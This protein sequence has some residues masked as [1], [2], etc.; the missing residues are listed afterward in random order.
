M[1]TSGGERLTWSTR[2]IEKGPF[3]HRASVCKA[4]AIASTCAGAWVYVLILGGLGVKDLN[5]AQLFVGCPHNNNKQQT[6]TYMYMD[7]LPDL[8]WG[9]LWDLGHLSVL[10]VLPNH[11]R[12]CLQ[13]LG[14][15][16]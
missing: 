8:V 12:E 15:W 10:C 13:C 5:V 6:S 2:L 7:R 16:L 14:Y 4:I 3:S 1:Y 9:D 11:S